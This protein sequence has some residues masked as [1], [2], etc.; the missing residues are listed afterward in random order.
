MENGGMI[1]E[2]SY[3]SGQRFQMNNLL[4]V[5]TAHLSG[6]L[7]ILAVPDIAEV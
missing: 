7:A 5:S 1:H 4:G 6:L 2:R 3:S